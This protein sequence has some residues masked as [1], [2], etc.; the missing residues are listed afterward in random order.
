MHFYQAYGISVGSAVLLPELSPGVGRAP[1]AVVSRGDLPDLPADMKDAEHCAWAVPGG[2]C[3]FWRGVGV[4]AILGGKEIVLDPAPGLE[5]S[6]LRLFILGA[7]MAVLLHQRGLL[8]LHASAVSVG[9]RAAL[10]L[11]DKG[12]GKST[13]A[14]ALAARGHAVISD[15]VVAL[16]EDGHGRPT[17]MPAFPQIKLWPSSVEALGGDPERLPR[18]SALFDKRHFDVSGGFAESPVPLGRIFLLGVGDSVRVGAAGA[19]ESVLGLVR[20]S[21]SARFAAQLLGGEN[22]AR[23]LLQCSAL[24]RRVPISHLERPSGLGLLPDAVRAVEEALAESP[25]APPQ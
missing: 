7:A 3:L 2:L 6:R 20:H 4:I 9:G 14:A 5:E 15:D 21:Y 23:H 22:G 19:R 13:L 1:D 11:G 16:G 18:L 8:V 24:A 17:V 25:G 12:W 10:F